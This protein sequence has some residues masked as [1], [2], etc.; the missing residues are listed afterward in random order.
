MLYTLHT[1]RQRVK[2]ERRIPQ[3]MDKRLT[4]ASRDEAGN[5]FVAY[6]F[7]PMHLVFRPDQIDIN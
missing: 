1:D 4:R 2:S 6:V 7:S 5:Y 3:R